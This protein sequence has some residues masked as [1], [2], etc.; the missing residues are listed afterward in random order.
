M[1]SKTTI[2]LT[3]KTRKMGKVDFLLA[4][5]PSLSEEEMN[6]ILGGKKR[7]VKEEILDTITEDAIPL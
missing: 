7:K 3:S 6:S 4:S 2:C 5:L 1:N